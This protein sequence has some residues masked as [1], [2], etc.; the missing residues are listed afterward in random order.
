MKEVLIIGS[1]ISGM[2]A[3]IGCASRGAK[4]TLISP[5]PSE[6]SQSVMA[7]GG[8]NAALDHNHEG[9]SIEL[10]IE[11]T[12]KGGAYLAGPEAVRELCEDAPRIVEWLRK[13]GTVFSINE[14]G[15]IDQRAFGGQSCRRTCFCGAST[16]KQIV[17]ALIMEARRLEGKGLI[18]RLTGYH[19]HSALIDGDRCYGAALYSER[20]ERIEAFYADALIMATG[21]QNALFGKTTGSTICDGYAAGR[22]FMQGVELKNLEF[23]QY[24]PTTIETSQKRMLISEAARGEGGRLYYEEDGERVYFME[25]EFGEKGNLMPRD[26][27][28]RCIYLTGRQVWLDV[29]FLGRDH[30]DQRIP[31]IRDLCQKYRGID[32]SEESIPVA[33]S[34]HYFM[35][36]FA[37]DDDHRTNID[38]IYAVGECASRYHGANRL[39]GNSLLSAI[40]SGRVAAA[41]VCSDDG[42]DPEDE[43]AVGARDSSGGLKEI[44][45]RIERY[46]QKENAALEKMRET[47]STFPV[48]YIRKMLA[49][50]MAENLGIVRDEKALRE[51]LEDIDF[52]LRAAGSINFDGCAQAYANYSIMSILALAKATLISAASRK[53]SRGAHYR[54]DYPDT[55][56]AW[57]A[58]TVISY[59][60]GAYN[61]RLDKEGRYEN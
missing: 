60:E 38:G 33:P 56:E 43:D 46:I 18:R 14:E 12:L 7:A 16:G 36:G 3:A 35:G 50:T 59:D 10:H 27:V 61:V 40:H 55:E 29:S 23:I 30:I 25:D 22:L 54:S 1:G 44:S 6:R 9:D 32:I 11:D 49:E 58:A 45:D 2:T 15:E 39:G 47:K 31:E 20:D 41:A 24:H 34:V 19:F 4:A 51:G 13:I 48:T 5:L 21:G 57:R 17:T 26:V 8:I 37:V 28:S 53:E 42:I 52:Y